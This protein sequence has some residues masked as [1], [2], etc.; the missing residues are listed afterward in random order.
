VALA[1][2]GGTA[3]FYLVRP[4]A[5][6]RAGTAEAS[7]T[8]RAESVVEPAAFAAPPELLSIPARSPEVGLASRGRTNSVSDATPSS[9]ADAASSTGDTAPG[10]VVDPVPP[11]ARVTVQVY[12]TGGAPLVR[13]DDGVAATKSG[14]PKPRKKVRGSGNSE[15]RR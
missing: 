7:A 3:A 12:G 8:D 4:G 1:L 15:P 2:L 14:K 9:I 13:E 11:R 10:P 6:V 5:G